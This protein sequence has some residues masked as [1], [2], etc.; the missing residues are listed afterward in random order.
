[1]TFDILWSIC[2]SN[3]IINT[4][5]AILSNHQY[6]SEDNSCL[7]PLK[8]MYLSKRTS[9]LKDPPCSSPIPCLS[10]SQSTASCPHTGF[11]QWRNLGSGSI[12]AWLFPRNRR[13]QCL[14]ESSWIIL[15]GSAWLLPQSPWSS[16]IQTTPHSP[17]K[18]AC[19]PE[20]ARCLPTLSHGP[21]HFWS[22][23]ALR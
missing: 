17:Q 12:S 16:P 23:S 19:F 18:Y 6:C 4:I 13:N 10:S 5:T 21:S 3:I 22:Q 1:M 9:R 14:L 2:N 7:I 15:C 20:T 11:W 8:I